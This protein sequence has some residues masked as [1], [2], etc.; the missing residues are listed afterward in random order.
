[1]TITGLWVPR[2]VAVVGYRGQKGQGFVVTHCL[3]CDGC[4]CGVLSTAK[5]C[6]ALLE[7]ENGS[8]GRDLRGSQPHSLLCAPTSCPVPHPWPWAP[9]LLPKHL[10]TSITP[11]DFFFSLVSLVGL[12]RPYLGQTTTELP[13]SGLLHFI[14][15]S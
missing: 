14:V 5:P 2:V 15:S 1:M 3:Q 8:V 6:L 7:P 13:H 9:T 11:Q 10:I 12:V 4:H